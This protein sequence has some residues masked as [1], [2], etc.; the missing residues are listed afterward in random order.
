MSTR[1]RPCAR[2]GCPGTANRNNNTGCC[3][4]VCSA[5]VRQWAWLAENR[6]SASTATEVEY[7]DVMEA[8]LLALDSAMNDYVEITRTASIDKRRIEKSQKLR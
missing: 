8:E 3:L 6:Q 2:P 1:R 4:P 5:L 7:L